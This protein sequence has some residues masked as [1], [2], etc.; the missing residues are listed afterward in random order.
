VTFPTGHFRHLN[1]GRLGTDQLGSGS[2]AFTAGLNVS[3]WLKPFIFYGNF[4]YT[5]ATSYKTDGQD[6]SGF[7]LTV[8]SHPRDVV[9]VNLAVEWPFSKRW[10]ALL[11]L[12]SNWD[13]GRLVGARANQVSTAKTTLLPGLEFMATEKLS[14]ALGVG[15]DLVGK[16]IDLSYTPMFSLVYAF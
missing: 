14:F 8:H 15:I 1:P 10:I 3:K 9:T 16:N 7:P 4:W 2:Y 12:Y 5:L 13:G 6:A 11:E